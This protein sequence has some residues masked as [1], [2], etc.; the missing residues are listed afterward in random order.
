MQN[1]Q[2]LTASD[3]RNFSEVSLAAA[4]RLDPFAANPDQM[5]RATASA[6]NRAL[7]ALGS[8]RP[9]LPVPK[10][11]RRG[12]TIPLSEFPA[13]FQAH[14]EGWAERLRGND[15]LDDD[16]PPRPLRETTIAHRRFQIQ[17]FVSA[18]VLA[19][20]P[21]EAITSLADLLQI[22]VYKAAVRYLMGRFGD[23]PTEAIVG[24][25]DGLN[26]IGRHY[27]KLPDAHFKALQRIRAK[28]A[29]EVETEGLRDKNRRRL[30][31]FEDA[32]NLAALLH[33]PALLVEQAGRMKP[34]RKAA[35]LVEKAVAIELLL[36][37]ALRIGSLTALDLTAISTGSRPRAAPS[38]SLQR[39]RPRP[40]TGAPRPLRSSARATTSCN[41]I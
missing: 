34:G 21:R 20:H 33:L 26:A 6:W 3:R 27:V 29:A 36:M 7:A 16:A 1:K 14:V 35:I 25:L 28:L 17:E 31:Q 39:R 4:L 11:P 10:L 38:S 40:R 5:V 15:L 13:I 23:K 41:S 22:D 18:A 24:I 30:A 8:N 9:T 2:R 32:R 19:G 37:T 12:W